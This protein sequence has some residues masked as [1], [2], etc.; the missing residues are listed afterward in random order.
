MSDSGKT[1]D[2]GCGVP[3]RVKEDPPPNLHNCWR[4]EWEEIGHGVRIRHA[5]VDGRAVGLDYEH[6]PSGRCDGRE[7]YIPYAMKGLIAEKHWKLE[8]FAP[9]TLSP[10][11]LCPVCGHHGFIRE[12]KWVPA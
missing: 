10:S 2:I 6:P 5:Y 1:I 8:H 7:S 9:T 4:T 11:L 12:G 3:L